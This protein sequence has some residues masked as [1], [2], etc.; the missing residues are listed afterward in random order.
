MSPVKVSVALCTF[1][2]SD[3]ILQQLAS[4]AEQTRLPDEV[5]LCDDC[6]TDE[7][8]SIVASFQATAP[9]KLL[10]FKNPIQ[11]GASK[12]F[13]KAITLCTG[14]VIFLCDQD[15][16][17]LPQKVAT[18][19]PRFEIND[20]V[21]LVFS[22]ATVVD[23]K[24]GL[25]G[26]TVWDNFTLHK[27]A[28]AELSGAN[29]L[30]LLIRRYVVTGATAAFRATLKDKILPIANGCMHDAWISF[31]VASYAKI[32]AVDSALVL[33]RQHDGNVVGGRRRSFFWKV[34]R[35]LQ[36]VP[37]N[38]RPEILQATQM[39]NK[40]GELRCSNVTV[41]NLRDLDEKIAHLHARQDIFGKKI[42]SRLCIVAN[43]LVTRR[44]SRFS[45]GILS[46]LTDLF[47][48]GSVA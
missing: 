14:D 15:D 24:L 35:T 4:I 5:V 10:C 1:N 44:Y 27:G 8:L 26:Y 20:G 43:E 36:M 38:L 12:N 17:W 21:G 25:M 34:N 41:E 40:L 7:T 31:V 22:N 28:L 48:R 3:F 37:G 19:L 2:G 33:Y 32:E 46:A 9:F 6:S 45:R 42:A 18:M 16:V 29:P 39:R 11:L 47:F 13:E 30:A 23:S